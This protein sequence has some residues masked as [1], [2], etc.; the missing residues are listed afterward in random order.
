MPFGDASPT[1][2]VKELDDSWASSPDFVSCLLSKALE[3][4]KIVISLLPELYSQIYNY[5]KHRCRVD[6]NPS[7]RQSL[8]S[9]W[10]ETS[11]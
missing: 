10:R 3:R 1:P 11:C 4:P 6:R 2:S 7:R 5:P 8:L 9:T